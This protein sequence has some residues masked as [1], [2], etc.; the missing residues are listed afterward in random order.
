MARSEAALATQLRVR[1]FVTQLTKQR[2]RLRK[3]PPEPRPP[4]RATLAYQKQLIDI[5]RALER[6][7]RSIIIAN[8]PALVTE[9]RIPRPDGG[10]RWDSPAQEIN[11]M[12]EGVKISMGERMETGEL[13]GI[14]DRVG[15]EV[16]NQNRGQVN[17]VLE[18][19]LGIS[20]VASE[21]WLSDQLETFRSQNVSLINTLVGDELNQVEGILQRGSARGLS[22]DVLRKQIEDRFKIS[23]GRAT[24][25]ARDQTNKLNGQ[26]T[27]LRQQQA[28]IGKYTWR[29]SGDG[30]VRDS[31]AELEGTV[32]AWND[33]P[34]T[35]ANGDRNHPGEDYNCRCY[36]EP[37]LDEVVEGLE[38]IA[39]SPPTPAAIQ[40][41]ALGASA[42]R[43]R[44]APRP[45]AV[46]RVEIPTGPVTVT[47]P[48]TKRQVRLT[49]TQARARATASTLRSSAAA[50]ARAPFRQRREWMQWEWVHG[51]NR[52]TSVMM[53]EAAR[54]SF[55]LNGVVYNPRGFKIPTREIALAKK[56]LKKIYRQTQAE[57][58]RKGITKVKLYRGLRGPVA[59]NGALESWTTDINTAKKFGTY[60]IQVKEVPI[61]RILISHRNRDWI[62]GVFGKQA[63]YVVM[64]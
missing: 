8:L 43:L 53:K 2:Q 54:R 55:N 50:R 52:K 34:V 27:R 57:F 16:S 37:V 28:G 21:P 19:T 29:T 31:H 42:R 59:E 62:D 39:P 26:L 63:E 22:V 58:R 20:Y 25:I 24:T 32:H 15:Q 14:A 36:A 6:A 41:A 56:D 51:S 46:P 40:R 13:G 30:L 38:A 33:P 35:N 44:P 5:Q 10:E 3:K 18:S 17:R 64:N 48:R 61:D 45:R 23:R 11:R 60:S 7:I 49:R 12:I 9:S 4:T 47:I 1:R